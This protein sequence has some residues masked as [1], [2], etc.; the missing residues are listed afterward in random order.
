M[1]KKIQT[2]LKLEIQAGK[3]TPAPPIGPVLGQHGLN[4]GQFCKDFNDRT[5]DGSDVVRV[6]L[7]VYEDKSYD[8][9]IKT[10]PTAVLLK[11]AAGIDKGSKTAQQKQAG[12]IT[13]KQLQE[14]ANKKMADLNTNDITA[15]I[16]IIT[17]TAKSMG[18]EIVKDA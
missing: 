8:F 14:I 3:A 16:K 1:A 15:A 12:Q 2:K 5:K 4:I 7:L 11:K 18:I 13:E 6:E 10:T 9:K 17:G